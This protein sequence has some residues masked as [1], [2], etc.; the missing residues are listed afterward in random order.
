MHML[1]ELA[2][3]Q[4]NDRAVL[5]RLHRRHTPPL[6]HQAGGRRFG[7]LMKK[8]VT[9]VVHLATLRPPVTL[10]APPPRKLPY[11]LK[12]SKFFAKLLR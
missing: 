6:E 4:Q 5:A 1:K 11:R 8:K 9:M 2:V 12:P 7:A 10:P 3:Q